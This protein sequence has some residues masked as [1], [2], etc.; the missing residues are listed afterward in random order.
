[1]S[2]HAVTTFYNMNVLA[3]RLEGRSRDYILASIFA[4]LMDSEDGQEILCE[5]E[6][7]FASL[8]CSASQAVDVQYDGTL[9]AEARCLL[10]LYGSENDR[11]GLIDD[12]DEYVPE[13]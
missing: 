9:I 11:R 10:K 2:D 1:M 3:V 12:E 7:A 4:M 13:E 5:S 6:E 8:L